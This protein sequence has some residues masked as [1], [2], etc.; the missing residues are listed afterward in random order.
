MLFYIPTPNMIDI[1]V[2]LYPALSRSGGMNVKATAEAIS[3][4]ATTKLTRISLKSL[5]F[6]GT[7]ATVDGVKL[8]R[9]LL[10]D[11]EDT[12]SFDIFFFLHPKYAIFL[13]KKQQNST[14]AV[15]IF[16]HIFLTLVTNTTK[17]GILT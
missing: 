3:R 14:A 11:E 5:T 10:Q 15:V 13:K 7:E 4:P 8:L 17:A 6:P 1:C 9:L 12:H 16:S 2:S